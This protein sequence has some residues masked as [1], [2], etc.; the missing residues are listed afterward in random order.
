LQTLSV[1]LYFP[2]NT[3]LSTQ[4]Y[5]PQQTNYLAVGDQTAN[6]GGGFNQ[7]ISCW[8]FLS[9]V[10]VQTNSRVLG[11]LITLGD[12]ITDG[13]NSTTDGNARYPDWLA[14]RL[15]RRSSATF[16]VSNAGISGNALLSNAYPDLPQLGISA[17]ARI[18]R[19]VLT[20]PG[21]RAVIL[22]EGTNDIGG[23]ATK[24]DDLIAVDRQIILQAHGA[25]LKI[26]AGT[27]IPFGGANPIWGGEYGTPF[28]EQQRQ[29]LNRW[30]LTS[31]AFDGVIDFDKVIRDPADPSRMLPAYDSGD[32]LHPNDSGYEAMA[33]EV[34]LDT[35][36]NLDR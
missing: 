22:L 8:M 17:P 28:G 21:A 2:V 26:Y 1:S 6:E 29:K 24:A 13:W 23:R 18:A 10:D 5:F 9:G 35:I 25:R 20:Q 36:V 27:L 34:D 7:P 16:S 3:G 19:D 12:S 33:N 11:A 31:G 30:I 14:R 15:V 4:H 32:H